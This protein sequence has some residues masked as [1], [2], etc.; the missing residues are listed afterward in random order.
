[1][2]QITLDAL[3]DYA[4]TVAPATNQTLA[5][6]IST[7][8]EHD[9]SAPIKSLAAKLKLSD[10]K[11]LELTNSIPANTQP[12]QLAFT[13]ASIYL[14]HFYATAHANN[15]LDIASALSLQHSYNDSDQKLSFKGN[16]LATVNCTDIYKKDISKNPDVNVFVT[17]TLMWPNDLEHVIVVANITNGTK[18]YHSEFKVKLSNSKVVEAQSFVLLPL[19]GKIQCATIDGATPEVTIPKGL[20]VS[21]NVNLNDANVTSAQFHAER[22]VTRS[23]RTTKRAMYGYRK[24]I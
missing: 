23:S 15:R 4:Q 3:K 22:K 20:S 24:S 19:D 6:M 17:H 10:S 11:R 1:M 9:Q 21:G 5:D 13:K 18:K 14:E 12:S 16:T 2:A 7:K 8:L